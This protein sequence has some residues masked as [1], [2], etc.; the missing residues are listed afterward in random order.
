MYNCISGF[1]A[2]NK[3]NNPKLNCFNPCFGAKTI[4]KKVATDYINKIVGSGTKEL[5]ISIHGSPDDDGLC[6][7]YTAS[8]VFFKEYGIKSLICVNKKEIHGLYHNNIKNVTKRIKKSGKVLALDFNDYNKIPEFLVNIFKSYKLTNI[9]GFKPKNK[10]KKII[11]I[12]GFDHHPDTKTIKGDFYID[13]TA[14]SCC[15]IIFRLTEALKIKLGIDDLKSLYCGILSDYLK[16]KLVKIKNGRLIKL[17]AFYKDKNSK[18]VLNKIGKQLSIKDK[19]EIHKHLDI[20]SN[21]SNDE[22]A[23]QTELFKEIKVTK[24]GKLACVA[25]P[26]SKQSNFLSTTWHSLGMKNMRT[27]AI[28]RDLRLRLINNI[29]KDAMFTPEQKEKLKDI[30]GAVIFYPTGKN[31]Y[32]LSIH[33]KGDYAIKLLKYAKEIYKQK[34][35]KSGKIK[36]EFVGD[37]H[38]NRAGGKIVDCT[39]AEMKALIGS[40]FEASEKAA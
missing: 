27:S 22:K 31:T 9:S 23:L 24:N 38:P 39:P 36:H 3:R 34:A 25:I 32:Q 18:E 2:V 35:A 5:Y 13:D 11:K 20:L 1:N 37:G 29:Q 14:R 40:F 4:S 19:I 16:S 12:F 17:S 7:A 15:G 33:S 26:I 28:L 21:L 8:N 6:A 10:N 30:R